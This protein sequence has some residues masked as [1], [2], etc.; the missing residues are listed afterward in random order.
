MTKIT[1]MSAEERNRLIDEFW[2]EVGEEL[3]SPRFAA[4]MR[5]MKPAL[6][7]APTSA[8]LEAWAELVEMIHDPAFRRAV[9][10]VRQ[11]TE[12]LRR[13]GSPET[14]RRSA[15]PDADEQFRALLRDVEQAHQAGEEPASERGRALADAYTSHVM[16]SRDERDTPNYRRELADKLANATRMQRYGMLLA[17]LNGGD[18]SISKHLEWMRW[19]VEALRASAG[20]V[21]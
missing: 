9:R 4:A 1:R 12:P 6:P 5:S 3:N 20:R 15:N 11:D 19:L 2:C 7:D 18:P 13:S 16:T 17:S 21:R 8:Q 10:E 14:P